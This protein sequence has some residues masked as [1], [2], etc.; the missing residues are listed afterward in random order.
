MV[1][2]DP[3]RV[4]LIIWFPPNEIRVR[5]MLLDGAV[6]VRLLNVLLPEIV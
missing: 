6:N 5:P 4:P 2:P 3:V 1:A